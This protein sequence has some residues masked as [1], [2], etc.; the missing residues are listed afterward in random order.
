MEKGVCINSEM[1]N[2]YGPG[3]LE[4]KRFESR[5]A[6]NEY[7]TSRSSLCLIFNFDGLLYQSI[8]LPAPIW[9]FLKYILLKWKTV[10]R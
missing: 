6:M 5:K 1:H 7:L 3:K 10:E 2:C 4:A 9:S 8:P